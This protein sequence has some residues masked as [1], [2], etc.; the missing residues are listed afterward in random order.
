[1]PEKGSN[2]ARFRWFNRAGG[3]ILLFIGSLNIFY[4]F[5]GLSLGWGI[6]FGSL[7]LLI[8]GIIMTFI[9]IFKLRAKKDPRLIK[10][11]AAS[12]VVKTV[13]LTGLLSFLVIEGLIIHSAL[14]VEDSKRDYIIILG[15]ALVGDRPTLDLRVR[16]DKSIAYAK[17]YPDVKMIL[18]GGQG[19]EELISEAE[20]MKRYLLSKGISG[21]NIYKEERSRNTF[22][23]IKY[24]KQVIDALNADNKPAVVIVSND[25]HIFRAKMLARRIGLDAHGLPAETPIYIIPNHYVREYFAVIKSWIFDR[26]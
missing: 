10:N 24:S 3:C 20:A 5:F 15:A 13:V 26:V 7:F 16:L 4:F 9:G 2:T 1:M 19:E 21:T 12:A 11:K 8:L 6:Y 23:N 22:E 25:F 14:D 18:S 17:K